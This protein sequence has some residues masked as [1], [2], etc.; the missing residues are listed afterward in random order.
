MALVAYFDM[1]TVLTVKGNPARVWKAEGTQ[2]SVATL[3]EKKTS[4]VVYLKTRIQ[5]ILFCSKLKNWDWTLRRDT[6]ENSQ[7]APGTKLNSGKKEAIWRHYPKRWTSGAKSLRAQFWEETLEETSRPAD[8]TS[9][10]A[11]NLARKYASQSRRQLRFILLWR[12][13][14]H[15]RS[16]VSYGFGSSRRFELRYNG[17]F[18]KVQNPQSDIPRPGAV[19]IKNK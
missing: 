10:V 17:C 3:K 4:K 12:C 11:W 6:P 2:G 9:K 14:R 18:E 1:L 19:P 16:Y 15:R 5:W 8:C 7:D 13:Q